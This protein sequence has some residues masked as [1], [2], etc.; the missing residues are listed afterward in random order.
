[1][2]AVVPTHRQARTHRHFLFFCYR[3]LQG[4]YY[5]TARYYAAS[6]RH[7]T[8]VRIVRVPYHPPAPG[9]KAYLLMQSTRCTMM[10]RAVLILLHAAGAAALQFDV[11]GDVIVIVDDWIR[12]KYVDQIIVEQV[13]MLR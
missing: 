2:P 1:M 11:E 6:I 13:K 3:L 8:S 9:G 10:L 5:R 7:S 12:R 4:S